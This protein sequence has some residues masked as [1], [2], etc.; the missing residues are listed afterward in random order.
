MKLPFFRLII[1]NIS[2]LI[3]APAE[4]D[5]EQFVKIKKNENTKSV[6]SSLAAAPICRCLSLSFIVVSRVLHNVRHVEY[7]YLFQAGNDE[8]S[9]TIPLFKFHYQLFQL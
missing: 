7:L 5:S 2:L 1:C 4:N 8:P 6:C 3:I 9:I